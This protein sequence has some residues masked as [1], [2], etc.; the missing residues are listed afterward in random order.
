[1]LH[2]LY[3]QEKT[4]AEQLLTKE[5]MKLKREYTVLFDQLLRARVNRLEYKFSLFGIVGRA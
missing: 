5:N 3:L 1:M 2:I 4:K